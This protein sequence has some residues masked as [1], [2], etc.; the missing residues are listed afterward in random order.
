M[1]A[2]D[3][4]AVR[5]SPVECPIS[6]AFSIMNL[7]TLLTDFGTQDAYVAQM[8]GEMLGIHPAACFVDIT[9]AVPPQDV[10]AGAF[11]LAQAVPFFPNETVHVA[12]VDPGVGTARRLIAVE[13]ETDNGEPGSA[14]LQRIVLPDNGLISLLLQQHKFIGANYLIDKVFWR[15]AISHTFHGRD[16]MGPVAAHWSKGARRTDFGPE[17]PAPVTLDL[18]VPNGAENRFSGKRFFLT[19]SAM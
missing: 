15:S 1:L 3:E 19:T 17:C 6:N 10:L 4:Q 14:R 8:K 9:H 13:I 2:A 7:I 18:V 5:H 16:I 11:L 12:V